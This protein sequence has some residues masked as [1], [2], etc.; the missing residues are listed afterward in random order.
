MKLVQFFEWVDRIRGTRFIATIDA[1]IKRI[2]GPDFLA[3]HPMSF[4]EA[5]EDDHMISHFHWCGWN[6]VGACPDSKCWLANGPISKFPPQEARKC[7]LLYKRCMQKLLYIRGEG[8]QILSKSH[9]IDMMEMHSAN[10]E[11]A[12]FVC[13]ARHPKDTFVSWMGFAQATSKALSFCRMPQNEAVAAH[14]RFW[15]LYT[16]KELEFFKGVLS[17]QNK[18]AKKTLVRF[19]DFAKNS[20]GVISS[21]YSAWGLEFSGTPFEEKIDESSAAHCS[22]KAK[23]AY[24]NPSLGDLELDQAFF[25]KQY[26]TYV[27]E[28]GFQE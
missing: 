27:A 20:K 5:A 22:D 19:P 26:A 15:E 21:L 13:I 23:Q 6:T 10:F 8:R 7:F 16:A 9:L 28:I 24:T 17:S 14:I 3:R 1:L 18:D 4:C 12:K 2:H 11:N 25:D